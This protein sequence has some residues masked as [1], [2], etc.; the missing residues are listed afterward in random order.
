MPYLWHACYETVF[1]LLLENGWREACERHG[2]EIETPAQGYQRSLHTPRAAARRGTRRSFIAPRPRY[3][4]GNDAS[5]T[6]RP[7]AAR[8]R[9]ATPLAL[10]DEAP[11]AEAAAA[12]EAFVAEHGRVGLVCF[13]SMRARGVG[14]VLMR[15]LSVFGSRKK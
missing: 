5:R 9:F 14:E 13:G 1:T 15:R 6:A 4:I 3:L 8:A 12:V 10:C 2:R 11:D 7:P